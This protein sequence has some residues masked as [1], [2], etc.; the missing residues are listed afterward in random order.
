MSDE[1]EGILSP[2]EADGITVYDLP[3]LLAD[4][5]MYMAE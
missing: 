4:A 2:V 1:D 5:G 3:T